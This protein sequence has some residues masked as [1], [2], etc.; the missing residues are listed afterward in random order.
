MPRT[1]DGEGEVF[2]TKYKKDGHW[3]EGPAIRAA[4][5]HKADVQRQRLIQEHEGDPSI[6]LLEDDE[7]PPWMPQ[8]QAR[9]AEGGA[10]ATAAPASATA[11]PGPRPATA[12]PAT[13][14]A[15]PGPRP[16]GNAPSAP[17]TPTTATPAAQAGTPASAPSQGPATRK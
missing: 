13:T 11:T 14:P 9:R 15:R 1:R 5:R 17:A 2:L 10:E 4:N 8:G 16:A 12:Q 7:P 3:V 6:T